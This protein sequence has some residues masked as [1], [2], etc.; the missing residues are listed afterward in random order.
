[1]ESCDVHT[2]LPPLI[3]FGPDDLLEVIGGE[4]LHFCIGEMAT[5]LGVTPRQFAY[6]MMFG[7]P[8]YKA[9][10]IPRK[11]PLEVTWK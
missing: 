5:A 1:M 11:K 6:A 2:Q 4:S 8:Q 9:Y 7:N 10:G 3:D